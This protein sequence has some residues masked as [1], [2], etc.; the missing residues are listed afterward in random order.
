M[1]RKNYSKGS[2]RVASLAETSKSRDDKT[3]SVLN[4]REDRRPINSRVTISPTKILER[5]RETMYVI[6]CTN[7]F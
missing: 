5:V 2:A 1:S 4:A 7:K 3:L 6:R